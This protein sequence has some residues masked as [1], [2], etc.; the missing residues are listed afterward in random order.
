MKKKPLI[1]LIAAILAVAIIAAAC[2][3]IVSVI[4]EKG[5]SGKS[6]KS[7]CTV[8]FESNGGSEVESQKIKKGETAAYPL[9][10]ER[11][12]YQFLGWYSDD[13]LTEL[14]DFSKPINRSCTLYARW[15][16]L[17]D[18]TDSDG[19]GIP[20]AAEEILGTDPTSD[21]PDGDGL[22]D[23]WELYC[24]L[25]PLDDDTDG[26]GTLDGDEDSD[27]DGLSNRLE[28]GCGSDPMIADTD[29]D[30][31]SDHDEINIYGTDP[32][33]VD[34]DGDGASDLWETDNSYDPL[35]YDYAFYVVE[36]S[37]EGENVSV[38]VE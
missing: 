25:D 34:T 20:D 11:E 4:N 3:I 22:S 37:S 32:V 14:F 2:V 23:K 18:D 10:P 6:K 5:S 7:T 35:S 12:G 24:G 27:S 28:I 13:E 1:I 29:G 30:G 38:T 17:S 16:D 8:T 31:L 26:D 15:F 33:N 19:D 36:S 9:P 21:D